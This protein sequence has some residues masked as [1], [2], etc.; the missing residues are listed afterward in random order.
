MSSSRERILD[1]Y[2]DVLAVDGERLA[3]VDAVAARAGVS[4]GGLLY[5]FRSKD[6]LADA[7]CDRLV[8]LAAVDVEE[9]RAADEGP[10]RYYIR[11][12]QY[13]DTPLS[14]ALVAVA[15]LQ[16]A[17][18]ERAREVIEQLSEQWLTVLDD[19]LG[20]REVARAIKL[21][22]DGLYHRAL[23]GVLGGQPTETD[24]LDGLLSIIDRLTN[25]CDS[26]ASSSQ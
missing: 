22:G 11:T 15:R 1:A 10:A 14:L 9:M 12:S 24:E 20:D 16:Q 18:H 13:A 3:T 25:Q 8:A 2:V 5:H 26:P 21:I 23:F 19:A 6:S 4:K 7:L 17:G